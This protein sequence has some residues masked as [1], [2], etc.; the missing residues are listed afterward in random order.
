MSAGIPSYGP[1]WPTFFRMMGPYRKRQLSASGP[2]R[3]RFV[4]PVR[5]KE[6][7]FFF[8]DMDSPHLFGCRVPSG[9]LS[10][11]HRKLAASAV[12]AASET[13]SAEAAD[14]ENQNEQI[15]AGVVVQEGITAAVS[16][17][18][19]QDEN[20]KDN[21]TTVASVEKSNVVTTTTIIVTAA[22]SS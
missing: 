17:E 15:A 9:T 13:I 4:Y 14:Q 8:S 10:L 7:T 1:A 19:A 20:Q 11:V 22:G 6:W 21:G 16:T 2:D 5:L 12:V 3:S 18:A